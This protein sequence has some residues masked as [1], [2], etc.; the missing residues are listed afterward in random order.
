MA[1]L[2][3]QLPRLS[4]YEIDK[5]SKHKVVKM[6]APRWRKVLKDIWSNKSRTTLV[7]LSIA[8]GVFSVGLVSNA[9]LMMLSDMNTDHQSVNPN[10]GVL[11]TSYFGDEELSTI[12]KIDGVELAEGRNSVSARVQTVSGTWITMYIVGI[13]DLENMQINYLRAATPGDTIF[14]ENK[15]ILIERTAIPLLQVQPGDSLVLE[16]GENKYKTIEVG[17]IVH[18]VTAVSTTFSG[19]VTAYVDQETLLWLGG[20]PYYTELLFTVEEN[21]MDKAYITSVADE[22]A[23]KFQK[24]GGMVYATVVMNPGEHYTAEITRTLLATLGFLGLMAVLLSAFLVV[25]TINA[26][27]GQHLRQIGMMKAI[28]ART[29]QIIGMYIVLILAFGMIALLFALPVASAA[30]YGVM[31]LL[32]NMLNYRMGGFRLPL[33]PILLQAIVA[34]GVPLL[35][36]LVPVIKGS[37]MTVKDAINNYGVSASAFGM[38]WFDRLIEK[39][40]TLPR[41]LLISI[42]NTFRRK[43]RL[44]LTLS[45]LT[46]AGAIFIAVFNVKAS[47]DITI[48]EVL[49]Y[50]LSDVNIDFNNTYH[51]RQVEDI[52]YQ[53]PGVEKIE[54]WGIIPADT[55][56]TELD[57]ETITKVILWA[58]PNDSQLVQPVIT[59][60]RW[61]IPEDQNA[62]VVGNHFLTER[63]DVKV[64]DQINMRILEKEHTFTVVGTFLM[65]GNVIPPF[66]YVNYDALANI[67]GGAGRTYGVRIVTTTP[68]PL[69]QRSVADQAE[70]QLK[71]SGIGISSITTGAENQQQQ[72]MTINI[73]VYCLLVM[74][75]LIALVGGVGL[76]GTMS[77]NVLE[78]TRE[79]GVMRSIGASNRSIR[80]LVVMESMLIGTISWFLGTLL[81]LPISKLLSSV[82]GVAFVQAPLTFRF[83]LDGFLIW[84]FVV[85]II[86]GIASLIPAT[87]AVKLTV[88][89]ILAYE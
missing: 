5:V 20:S 85:L 43:G 71:L 87:N 77:M 48:Q 55:V 18:D 10:S 25:N 64:G 58:P 84:L 69:L 39:L 73:L 22:I 15:K 54:S 7:V 14:L 80:S 37:Q 41:P 68:D 51:T 9:Y 83:A 67:I 11:Y 57:Q 78:R 24:G 8:I 72:M 36:A 65:A 2:P 23:K 1:K 60:G 59:S 32:A 34:F 40:H 38:N 30:N 6:M 29:D 35:A 62:V 50:F 4:D 21:K 82:I 66:L 26:L 17:S 89:D 45:T 42:R 28:G 74:A 33:L 27:L 3:A 56:Y 16:I 63:P 19:Q 53:I 79:I 61:L 13:P 52:L 46:L 76:M 75:A 47:F 86:S 70:E 81:A 88:R 49:G 12:N 44:F 31:S